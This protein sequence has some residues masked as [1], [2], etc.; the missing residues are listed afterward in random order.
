LEQ[1]ELQEKIQ[2]LI[3]NFPSEHPSFQ[4]TPASESLAF[5]FF[6][7]LQTSHLGSPALF[8]ITVLREHVENSNSHAPAADTKEKSSSGPQ[9]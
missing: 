8:L 2:M 5:F 1:N 6:H 9:M 4:N 3:Q 7:S